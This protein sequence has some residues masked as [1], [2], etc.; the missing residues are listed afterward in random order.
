MW[1]QCLDLGT[2]CLR[3]VL[4]SNHSCNLL[5]IWISHRIWI[6]SFGPE[7][8]TPIENLDVSASCHTLW[9]V[10]PPICSDA[11]HTPARP[12]HLR[13]GFRLRPPLKGAP[14]SKHQRTPP[15]R[16]RRSP[17]S[18]VRAASLPEHPHQ[19]AYHSHWCARPSDVAPTVHVSNQPAS[20]S[21]SISTS[22]S[23]SSSLSTSFSDS[24]FRCPCAALYVNASYIKK[25]I[26]FYLTESNQTNHGSKD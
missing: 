15:D 17:C 10:A 1:I 11:A 7:V 25:K 20:L 12:L 26:S 8:L 14:R 22:P 16:S 23:P 9:F 2:H 3:S 6:R 4:L 21:P 13:I 24:R 18:P 5:R 19:H